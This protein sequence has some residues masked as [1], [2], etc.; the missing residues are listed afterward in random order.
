MADLKISQLPA[1]ASAGIDA[2]D[3]VP[4]ADISASQTKKVTPLD[5]IN[6]GVRLMPAGAIPAS[7][8]DLSAGISLAAGSVGTTELAD[9]AVTTVKVADG[10]IT[11]A[12]ITGPIGLDKLAAASAATVLAGPATGASA[13]PAFR[14]LVGTDL[15]IAT[16]G[17][18]G[19][20][21]VSGTGA[22]TLA[23]DGTVDLKTV[24][25]AG[26]G[27]VVTF[28]SFGQVTA[29]R[30]LTGADLPAATSTVIGGVK[31]GAGL[32][33]SADG[34][35]ST[36]LAAGNLPLASSSAVGAVKPGAG[37]SVDAA[38][39]LGVTNNIP[40]GTGVKV[41]YNAQGMI[42][43]VSG[44]LAADIPVLDAAKITSGTFG[45]ARFEKGSVTQDKLADYAVSY[46]QEAV[47][48]VSVGAHPIGELWFQ[49][50]SARLSMWNGNSWMP[51][52]QGA[53]SGQNLRFCG[54]FD[55]TNGQVKAL[56]TFGASDG[57]TIGS[58]I[59]AA[60][61]NLTG[62][63]FVCDTAGNGTGVATGVA[64]DAGDWIVCLG[65]ARGWDRIDTLNGGGGG[66]ATT[67]DSL[68]DVAITTPAIGDILVFTGTN[69]INRQGNVDPGT[70]S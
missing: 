48:P 70:Y 61:N 49:E 22:L 9:G 7:K 20:V 27:A 33:V 38:G 51:V 65:Q 43:S 56:T 11:T 31:P 41:T 25:T 24:V 8:V 34:T 35:L 46:I 40:A 4:L 10:A 39:A 5:L 6:A 60:T 59:P 47:P 30:V 42:T 64:F 23:G 1:L 18:V 55:A 52:G 37:L 29:A 68:T 17:G 54:T 69:W 19:A 36:S 32:A 3:Q 2:T 67:L 45:T 14:A 50:S 12:K 15:P 28:N 21:K 57:F 62:A 44:L 26:S 13:T 66:G 16:T 58:A 53:L 63:Y